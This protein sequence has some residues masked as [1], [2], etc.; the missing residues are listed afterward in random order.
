MSV[1]EVCQLARVLYVVVSSLNQKA[2]ICSTLSALTYET[3]TV[4]VHLETRREAKWIYDACQITRHVVQYPK[5]KLSG[6]YGDI[7]TFFLLC[8]T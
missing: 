7:Y 6:I 3:D 1:K 4:N 8:L 2:Q 5:K